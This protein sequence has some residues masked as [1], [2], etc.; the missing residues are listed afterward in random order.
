M[1]YRLS[2]AL[3]VLLL[4]SSGCQQQQAETVFETPEVATITVKTEP[5][6]LTTELP[7]RTSAYLVSEIRPQVNGLIQKR[8][9]IEGSDIKQGQDLYQI[10]P[11]PFEAALDNSEA[12]LLA[13][14]KDAERARAALAATI[15]SVTR[16]VA[17]LELAESNLRRND[18]LYRQGAI[19]ASSL[20]QYVTQAKVAEAALKAA[21]AQVESDRQSIAAAEA[22]I[23]QAEAAVKIARI[24]LG[25]TRI[26]A[27][28]S[29]RIGKSNVTDGALVTAYQ[30]LALAT[31]QQ[32]DPIYVDVSQSISALLYLKQSM[33]EGTLN[34]NGSK[35]KKVKLIL[36][37]GMVYTSEGTLQF[38]DVTVD[39]STGA[40]TVRIVFPNPDGVLLPG[41]FVRA[42]AME[43]INEQAILVPQQSVSRDP[44]GNPLALVVGPDAKVEQ[45]S[46]TLDRPIGNKW[47]VTAGLKEGDHLIV[48]GLQKIRPGDSVNE[49]PFEE[50]QQEDMDQSTSSHPVAAAH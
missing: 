8:L 34:Q 37:D 49:V 47:L 23:L 25:Y 9:F 32:L 38:R 22:A 6:E 44:K 35:Q 42:V 20:D 18:E 4:A 50:E 40:V 28:I 21:R 3:G 26:T 31:V 36:D 13:A 1:K 11:A 43:G 41:M 19:P 2:L 48:E 24:N 46:L 27:P 45:K 16:E 39:P 33:E 12:S 29:G 17:N 14:R 5:V 10:D 30:P 7:G 15:A